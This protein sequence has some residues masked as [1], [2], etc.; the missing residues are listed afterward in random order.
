MTA[1]ISARPPLMESA[2]Q[3]TILRNSPPMLKQMAESKTKIT[4]LFFFFPVSKIIL[5]ERG[6]PMNLGGGE[7]PRARR[8]NIMSG[9]FCQSPS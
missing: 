8:Y 2:F 9:N 3:G 4:P 1:E 6:I 7:A 5:P